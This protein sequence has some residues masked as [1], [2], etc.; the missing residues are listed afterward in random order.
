MKKRLENFDRRGI[1][2]ELLGQARR[3]VKTV[4]IMAGARGSIATNGKET[5]VSLNMK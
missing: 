4:I 1:L 5:I 3:Y 2:E